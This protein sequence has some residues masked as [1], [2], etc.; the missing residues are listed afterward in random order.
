M[1][2][3][4]Y[5]GVSFITSDEIAGALLEYAAEL[6]N[7]EHAATVHVPAVGTL[8]E[9]LDVEVML[10]PAS[11][12]LSGPVANPG[13]EPDATEF[14]AEIAGRVR[15]LRADGFAPAKRPNVVDW[16]L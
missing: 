3:I 16:D 15:D 1:R 6:A 13:D 12:M 10:G 2:E 14:L 8:G 4:S 7:V 9:R 11:Q 5:A